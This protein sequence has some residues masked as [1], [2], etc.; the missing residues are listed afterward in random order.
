[1]RGQ[2]MVE[3]VTGG[4]VPVLIIEQVRIFYGAAQKKSEGIQT[5]NQNYRKNQQ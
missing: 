2:S 1:M 3:D 5:R 4:A